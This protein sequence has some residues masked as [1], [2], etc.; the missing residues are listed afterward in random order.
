MNINN[1]SA[2]R[3]KEV[4]AEFRKLAGLPKD[5]KIKYWSK[6]IA[7][8]SDVEYNI[9]KAPNGFEEFI[10]INRAWSYDDY[11][12]AKGENDEL[13]YKDM[14][15]TGE[16]T[17]ISCKANVFTNKLPDISTTLNMDYRKMKDVEEE[18]MKLSEFWSNIKDF[19]SDYEAQNLPNLLEHYC[20]KKLGV[21]IVDNHG[22]FGKYLRLGN[23]GITLKEIKRKGKPTHQ[24]KIH[25][26][27]PDSNLYFGP[28]N[29]RLRFHED[30]REE[31]LTGVIKVHVNRLE[32]ILDI[33]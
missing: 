16:I 26:I 17:S 1:N 21:D 5:R 13:N 28:T 20:R 11:Q 3:I 10:R 23:G 12:K 25:F 33:N 24:L 9:P 14:I 30:S 2:E 18:A 19:I 8:A 29:S 22:K 31:D 6:H 4:E 27:S 7:G 15:P 32:N